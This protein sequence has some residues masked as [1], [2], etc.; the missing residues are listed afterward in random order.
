MSDPALDAAIARL[1]RAGEVVI[2]ELP[3]HEDERDEGRCE[4]EMVRQQGNWQVKN[5]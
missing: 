1:R 3:G 5:I 2:Q 4:R